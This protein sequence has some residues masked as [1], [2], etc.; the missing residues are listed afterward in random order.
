MPAPVYSTRF[1]AGTADPSSSYTVPAGKVAVVRSISVFSPV[2]SIA[3]NFS[4][5][6]VGV[7]GPLFWVTFQTTERF[8]SLQCNQVVKAG[9]TLEVD[10]TAGSG[11]T[12][13]VSGFL[14]SEN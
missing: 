8:A 10:A 14:L 12:A 3:V 7:T 4:C 11:I 9:E 13:V 5:D 6:I 1:I 2:Q